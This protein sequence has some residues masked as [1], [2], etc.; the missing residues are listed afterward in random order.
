VED[1]VVAFSLIGH[2]VPGHQA[3]GVIPGLAVIGELSI[4]QIFGVVDEPA[5]AVADVLG[6]QGSLATQKA[7]GTKG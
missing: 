5:K 6:T 1:V 3:D 7:A 2:I 4:G